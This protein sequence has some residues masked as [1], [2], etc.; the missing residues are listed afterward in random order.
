MASQNLRGLRNRTTKISFKVRIDINTYTYC[1]KC[2]FREG[3]LLRGVHV[4]GGHYSYLQDGS[5][6]V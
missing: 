2:I 1:V 4:A 6:P 3:F 5:K